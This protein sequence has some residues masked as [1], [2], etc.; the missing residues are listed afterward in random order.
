M[1]QALAAA[2]LLMLALPGAA[3]AHPKHKPLRCKSG[4]QRET[5]KIKERRHGKMVRVRVEVCVKRQ[6]LSKTATP[7]MQA[8]APTRTVKLHAHLDPSFTRDPTDPF[9][10]IYAYSASATSETLSGG[11]V[12]AQAAESAP[13][14]EGVLELYSDGSLACAINVGGSTTGG[15][16]PVE[17]S[18]LGTHTVTTVYTSAEGKGAATETQT[19]TVEPFAGTIT[20]KVSYTSLTSSVAEGDA[21]EEC[22]WVGSYPN[23]KY[24]CWAHYRKYLIGELSI[25]ATATTAYG[26]APGQVHLSGPDISGNDRL[27]LPVCALATENE[28]TVTLRVL[29]TRCPTGAEEDYKSIEGGPWVDAL[30][31]MAVEKGT[32]SVEAADGEAGAGYAVSAASRPLEFTPLI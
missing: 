20:L 31:A 5:R 24:E 11:V 28:P 1:R 10:V 6:A 3:S 12:L 27:A 26:P 13:L 18:K 7:P 4:Y 9:K 14:P 30:T 22:G 2:V 8:P 17:Y 16:C 29:F 32:Y 19:E 15:E 21:G 23:Q 25:E